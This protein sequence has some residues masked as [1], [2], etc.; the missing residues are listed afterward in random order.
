ML[1]ETNKQL[2][3]NGTPASPLPSRIMTR[4]GIRK[5]P[6]CHGENRPVKGPLVRTPLQWILSLF[7][8]V[9]PPHA[10]LPYLTAPR[11]GGW[12]SRRRIKDSADVVPLA[13]AQL[14]PVSFRHT[15]I[16]RTSPRSDVLVLSSR[17][18]ESKADSRH[19]NPGRDNVWSSSAPPPSPQ[20]T[21][22]SCGFWDCCPC[23][24][25]SHKSPPTA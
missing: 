5:I 8:S 14:F 10:L 2:Q 16:V 12:A 21:P 4:L 3:R 22:K 23:T 11:G 15:G 18:A 7:C 9:S 17:G 13:D 24:N 19:R 6:K 20:E 25:S 1:L